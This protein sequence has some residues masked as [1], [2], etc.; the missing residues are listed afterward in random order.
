VSDNVPATPAALEEAL[1]LA[2][3]LLADIELSRGTLTSIALKASR[4]ARLLN[5]EDA[6][7]IFQYEASG[8]PAEPTMSAERWRLASA[9]GRTFEEKDAKS[10]KTQTYAFSESVEQLE[11]QIETNKLALQAA[12]DGDVSVSSANPYQVVQAPPGNMN[13]RIGI[14]WAIT[15]SA[16]RLSS[17]R[18]F[19]H[20]YV[21][22]RY[23]ELK[24]SGVAEDVFSGV[25][26]AVD[27]RI[28]V[29]VPAAV[30][31]F[32]SVQDNLRSSNPEDWSNAVHS[33]R[34]I[35]QD[36]ADAVF[37]STDKPR[38]TADGKAIKLGPDAY[39]NRLICYAEDNSD[40]SRFLDLVGSHLGFLGDRLEAVFK[41][42][43]KGSHS[44]VSRDEANRYVI[45][46]Y[47]LVADIL[48]LVPTA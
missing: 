44:V 30:Q 27:G 24:F 23:Y 14:R 26:D 5:D 33:C 40:S 36:L 12:Q 2:E 16:Q 1:T 41:A 48:S 7:E 45:Y 29:I 6:Q 15:Q 21:S 18:E 28:S 11:M 10:G 32:A 17:R 35:L 20:R 43:Q 8:Y 38:T 4:L 13:E 19:I 31:K 3:E 25:R 42:A 46:T 22:R 37:P 9:A 34:R 39:V 47:M